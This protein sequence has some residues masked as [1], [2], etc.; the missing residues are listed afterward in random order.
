MPKCGYYLDDYKCEREVYKK[1]ICIFHSHDPKK[2]K[3]FKVAFQNE[4]K[5]QWQINYDFTGFKFPDN[6]DLR[7]LYLEFAKME[8]AELIGANLEGLCLKGADLR[9]ADLTGANLKNVD[10]SEAEAAGAGFENANFEGAIL[11]K[12]KLSGAY[13]EGANFKDVTWK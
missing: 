5:R 1:G 11:R 3:N 7:G 9:A 6:F 13:I 10:L 2:N 12:V 4:M 8:D